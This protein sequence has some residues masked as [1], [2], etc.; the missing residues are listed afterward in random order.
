MAFSSC[1]FYKNKKMKK[2]LETLK[3]YLQK[4]KVV[5]FGSNELTEQ[6]KLVVER[7]KRMLDD[8]ETTTVMVPGDK[9]YLINDVS[10]KMIK[11]TQSET[12]IS[13]KGLFIGKNYS[14]KFQELLTKLITDH[15]SAFADK[16]DSD[17]LSR[18]TQ[19]L[20][21]ITPFKGV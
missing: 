17:L 4:A 1:R 7:V 16:V 18:E 8:K 6:E 12:V 10:G 19:S 13:D 2:V 3:S 15:I 14:Y 11:V 5:L 20:Q 9:F 21:E